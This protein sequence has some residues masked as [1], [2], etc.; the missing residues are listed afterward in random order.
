[1]VMMVRAQGSPDAL[2]AP[3]HEALRALGPT[4]AILGPSLMREDRRRTSWEQEF[5]GEMMAAFAGGA[6]LLA[7]LGIYALISYSVGRRSREIG[8]RLA[9]GARPADVVR[10]L[11]RETAGVGGMGLLLGVVFAVVVAQALAG[12]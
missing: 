7:C 8:V 9:L 1:M 4:F 3:T 2:L 10:M 12:S 5:F 11:L 6:L